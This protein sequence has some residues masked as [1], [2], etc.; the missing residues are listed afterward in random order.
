MIVYY[1][2]HRGPDPE[3]HSMEISGALSV[4]RRRDQESIALG[5]AIDF[6]GERCD[7]FVAPISLHE[8]EG[9]PEIARF[10]ITAAVPRTRFSA[11]RVSP[12]EPKP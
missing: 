10:E 1:K 2:I 5:C 7:A 12:P 9:G 6:W 11:V 8:S 3:T 4:A